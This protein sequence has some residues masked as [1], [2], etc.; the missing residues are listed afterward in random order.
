VAVIDDLKAYLGGS[1]AAYTDPV[2]LDAIATETAAQARK[3]KAVHLVTPTDDLAEALLR[4][5]ARNLAVRVLPLGMTE[6][7]GDGDSRA[8]LP[9][10]DPE[11]R[12]LEGPYRRLTF[13]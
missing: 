6:A 2:L 3:V 1:A 7:S 4:R 13:G 5:C 12:R 10:S 8:Y 11:V 9:G